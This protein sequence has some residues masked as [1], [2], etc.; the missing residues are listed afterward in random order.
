LKDVLASRE[1]RMTE[2]ADHLIGAGGKRVRP[3]V[4]LLAFRACGGETIADAVDVAVALELIH[5]AS[6]LHDD[7]IDDNDVRRG[8][9]SARRKYGVAHTLV[10]GDFLF[11]RAFQICGRFDAEQ[12]NWAA[13]ACIALTEGEIMQ[14]RFRNNCSV[15]LDDYLEIIYRK[16]ASLFE[17]GAR[18]AASLAR[19]DPPDLADAIASC[20]RHVGLTFQIVDDLLDVT[21]D[22]S[23]LGKPVGLDVREGNPALPLVLAIADD[24]EVARLFAKATL[25]E[26]EVGAVLGRLRRSSVL[27]RGHRLALRYGRLAHDDLSRLPASRY[28]D[29]LHALIE[30]L[31]TRI[32]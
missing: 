1:P 7:I 2:I 32:A 11:S 3:T 5:S 21:A 28:R 20:A 23:E 12:I 26:G 27:E 29:S 22:E 4:T 13:E 8:R 9:D 30:Q 6:L 19:P 14:S 18:I 16:T 24:P 15:T 31:L 25:S 10:A 17:Q